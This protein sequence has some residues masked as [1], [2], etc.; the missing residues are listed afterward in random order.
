MDNR[1][2]GIFDSGFGGLT[3]VKE[4]IRALPNEN[5]VY[6]GDNGRAPYGNKTVQTLQKFTFQDVRF[7]QSFD[8]KLLVI[9]CNTA[10]ATSLSAILSHFS[11]PV[12]E[13]IDAGVRAVTELSEGARVGVIGT[14][15]TIRS[16]VYQN[17]VLALK[18]GYQVTAKECPLFVPLVEEGWWE[19]PIACAVAKEYLSDFLET[20]V[21]ALLLG[22]TH[23]PMLKKVLSDVLGTRTQLISSDVEV[24]KQVKAYLDRHEMHNSRENGAKVQFY[25]SDDVENFQRVG[26]VILDQ[27]LQHV[28]KVDIEKYE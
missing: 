14:K 19:H 7:L 12:V 6:F 21:E 23:Y 24:A 18:K 15:A 27:E 2:I 22:C 11:L 28:R 20:P 10:S 25:T 26:S 17:K 16:G 8:I 13:V 1:P 3:V 5:I 9:A 4:V